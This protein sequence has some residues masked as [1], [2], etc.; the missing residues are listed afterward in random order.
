MIEQRFGISIVNQEGTLSIPLSVRSNQLVHSLKC[1]AA[2]N[3]QVFV[4]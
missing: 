4:Y 1:V 2:S 3:L